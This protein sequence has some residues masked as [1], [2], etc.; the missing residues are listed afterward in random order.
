M[1]PRSAVSHL[2]HHA[3]QVFEQLFQ[4]YEQRLPRELAD[5][6]ED[7]GWLDPREVPAD[8]CPA[9]RQLQISYNQTP[10]VLPH[11]LCCAPVLDQLQPSEAHLHVSST[12]YLSIFGVSA[13]ETGAWHCSLPQ[14]YSLKGLWD[15]VPMVITFVGAV[16][17]L[18]VC[19]A[20]GIFK[21]AL[22]LWHCSC[23][24]H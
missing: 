4:A 11:C 14:E 2:G 20:I 8:A 24:L 15:A 12:H 18:G 22:F 19:L 5:K 6:A 23:Q 17:F 1:L 7:Q 9:E 13:I 21:Y 16:S 10:Q 3:P